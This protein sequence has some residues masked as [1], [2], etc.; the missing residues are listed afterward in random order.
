MRLFILSCVLFAISYAQTVYTV[1]TQNILDGQPAF[2]DVNK[3]ETVSNA[4]MTSVFQLQCIDSDECGAWEPSGFYCD[5]GLCTMC[6]VEGIDK[7][8]EG[9]FITDIEECRAACAHYVSGGASPCTGSNV[10]TNCPLGIQTDNSGMFCNLFANGEDGRCTSCNY[11]V[12]DMRGILDQCFAIPAFTSDNTYITCAGQCEAFERAFDEPQNL[13]NSVVAST[14]SSVELT[15]G[16]NFCNSFG[17]P[18]CELGSAEAGNL[19]G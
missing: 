3:D 12:T 10:K 17:Q 14:E 2:V 5:N 19:A 1:G 18:T 9:I 16:P 8:V 4:K 11:I 13:D 7:C 6:P 15:L